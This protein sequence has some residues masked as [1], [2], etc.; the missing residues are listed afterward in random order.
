MGR[1]IAPQLFLIAPCSH[2]HLERE[3]CNSGRGI[4][5]FGTERRF[6]LGA[7]VR[8][9]LPDPALDALAP[10]AICM[11]LLAFMKLMITLGVVVN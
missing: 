11:E 8:E 4:A 10:E 3:T 9:V 2:A 5:Y 1:V 6:A 7:A